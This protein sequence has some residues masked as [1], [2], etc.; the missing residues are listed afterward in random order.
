M[1]EAEEN[2]VEPLVGLNPTSVGSNVLAGQC[3]NGAELYKTAGML[4]II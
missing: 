3:Q 2:A 1:T 4:S